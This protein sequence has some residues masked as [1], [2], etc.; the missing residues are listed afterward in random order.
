MP[1]LQKLADSGL[2]YSQ[3]HTTA[4]CSPTR[5]TFL[6]GRNHHVNGCIVHH[7]SRQG[8]PRCG[9][10][11]PAGVRHHRPGAA[12]QRLQ[13]LLAGQE[14]QR[15]E[16]DIASGASRSE[17]PLQKGFDRFYGFLGG[18]TNHWYPGPGRGQQ[19]HRPALL[20]GA[21]LPPLEGP[22]R[23]GDQDDPRPEGHQSL[24]AVVHVVLSGA[25]HAPHHSPK[26]YIDKYKGKFDDGYEAYREWVLPRM[27]EKGILP[28]ERNAH[29]DQSAAGGR[30]R[31]RPVTRSG[32]GIAERGREEAVSRMAEVYAGFS[33][34]TDAQIGRIIDYLEQTN[35]LENTVVFYCADNGASGE[36]SPNGS[37]NENKFFNGYPDELSENM[38]FLDVLGGRTPT[39]TIRRDGRPRSP[40]RSR[41]SSATPSTPAAPATRW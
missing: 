6:T 36:G 39:T 16:Q 9:G 15:P 14:P 31:R 11:M 21:G 33:E 37:V 3:W 18:E 38:K 24:E 29:A 26:E 12:G 1:T 41:C 2:T 5:S 17:W 19:V 13:H 23:S 34:Y 8:L 27:I 7:R 40:R 10:R 32:R 25:N 35:Q 22:R 4:L 20:A 28:K 30:G